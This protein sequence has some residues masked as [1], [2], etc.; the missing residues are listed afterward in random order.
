[1]SAVSRRL[2]LARSLER[3]RKRG[4]TDAAYTT[5]ARTRI[6]HAGLSSQIPDGE[7]VQATLLIWRSVCQVSS[8]E[9]PP[10][11]C[12]SGV[13]ETGCLGGETS[14]EVLDVGQSHM[15]GLATPGR[16]FRRR[17]TRV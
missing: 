10:R 15:R 17:R 8:V 1:V 3:Y 6:K 16:W 14:G 12:R 11:C 4:G 7:F 5:D 2:T 9:C 13:G